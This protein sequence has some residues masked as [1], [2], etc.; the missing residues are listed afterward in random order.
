MKRLTKTKGHF[1][2]IM[3]KILFRLKDRVSLLIIYKY[4]ISCLFLIEGDGTNT[5][6]VSK[7]LASGKTE[8]ESGWTS[9]SNPRK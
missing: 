7:D 1:L 8:R 2:G 4:L 9:E 3:T 5:N 6:L